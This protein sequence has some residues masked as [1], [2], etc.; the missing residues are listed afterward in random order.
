MDPA[1]SV[2]LAD[3]EHG[4]RKLLEYTFER[5]GCETESYASGD[6]CWKRLQAGA[7]PDIVILDCMLPG[8][9]GIDVLKRI[10]SDA[11]LSDTPVVFVTG[12]GDRADVIDD[13][14]NV[15][16]YITKPFSPNA[17]CERVEQ[18]V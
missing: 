8:M 14:L 13:D 10:R 16:D 3:D 1:P 11:A 18:L 17:L 12:R 7:P 6:D 15:D 5:A 2:V 9:D 4:I